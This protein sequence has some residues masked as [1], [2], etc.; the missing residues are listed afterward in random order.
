MATKSMKVCDLCNRPKDEPMK[1]SVAFEG[2][3]YKEV[4]D[5]CAKKMTRF[6]KGLGERKS[7]KDK[8]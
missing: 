2:T 8:E 6:L 5:S 1:H 7:S 4:C 3:E